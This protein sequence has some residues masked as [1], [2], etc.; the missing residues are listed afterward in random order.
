MPCLLRAE[1]GNE[2]IQNTSILTYTIVDGNNVFVGY[3][4]TNL[5]PEGNVIVENGGRLRIKTNET[6]TLT[7]CVEVKLGGRLLI[8]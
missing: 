5:K 2:Y 4:V 7:K 8:L 1:E 3:D 6:T